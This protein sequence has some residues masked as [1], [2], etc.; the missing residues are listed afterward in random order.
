MHVVARETN[1]TRRADH[2]FT[3]KTTKRTLALAALTI[4]AAGARSSSPQPTAARTSGAVDDL[5]ITLGTGQSFAVLA[6]LTVTNTGSTTIYG[7]RCPSYD[8]SKIVPTSTP[9]IA[10]S[11]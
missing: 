9:P 5:Q 2:A 4:L 10:T 11:I 7:S 3:M 1:G 6:A 8:F